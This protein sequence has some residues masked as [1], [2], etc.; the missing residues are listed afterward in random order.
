MNKLTMVLLSIFLPEHLRSLETI[1]E[2][3]E[4]DRKKKELSDKLSL[5]V[6]E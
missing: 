3:V 1:S 2:L 6:D 5:E 4:K